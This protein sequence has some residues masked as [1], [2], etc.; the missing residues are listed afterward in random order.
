MNVVYS[1]TLLESIGCNAIS[2]DSVRSQAIRTLGKI[3]QILPDDGVYIISSVLRDTGSHHSGRSVDISGVITKDGI[4]KFSTHPDHPLLIK[5]SQHLFSIQQNENIFSQIL[6]PDGIFDVRLGTKWT[7]W[8]KAGEFTEL[9]KTHQ[10]H[11]H[12]TVMR[13]KV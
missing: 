6:A 10:D 13:G 2:I 4:K 7:E 5:L 8:E 1:S 9:S 11:I 12:I 3:S